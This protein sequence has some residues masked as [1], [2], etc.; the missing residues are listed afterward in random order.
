MMESTTN[1]FRSAFETTLDEQGLTFQVDADNTYLIACSNKPDRITTAKLICSEPINERKHGTKNN[2]EIK[3][4]GYFLFNFS[5]GAM[6]P[7]FYSF[8][9]FNAIDNKVDFVIIPT[10]ELR[11]RLGQRKCIT[12]KNQHPGLKF[13]LLP[14]NMLFETSNFG[15]EGEWWF[16]AGRMAKNTSWDYTMFLNDWISL[17]CNF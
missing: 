17:V 16:I 3:A 4:I 7:D 8:A 10:V 6:L 13:W 9:F 11:N 14:D 2:T 15:A 5:L 12:D 1:D